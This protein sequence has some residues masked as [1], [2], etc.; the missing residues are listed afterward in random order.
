MPTQSGMQPLDLISIILPCFDEEAVLPATLERLDA[1]SIA[2]KDCDFEFIFIDDGSTDGTNNLLHAAARRDDRL[3]L[4]TLSRNFGQ[5]IAT[6]A[7]IDLANGGAV[8]LMDCDLQDPPELVTQMIARW[9]EGYDVVYG[10]RASREGESWFKRSTARGFNQVI[11]RLSEVPIPADS[12]D[13]RLMSRKVVDVLKQMPE[14][15]RFLRGMVAW[16]GFRQTSLPYD[17]PGRLAGTTKY[18]LRKMLRLALDGLLSFST[19]PLQASI[20]LGL[21]TAGLAVLG[22]FY[23]L[24]MRLFTSAWVEGWT[25]LMIAILFI[26]GVQLVSLGIIGEYIGRIYAEVQRRPLYIVR[27]MV[28]FERHAE[29]DAGVH[30]TQ[31]DSTRIP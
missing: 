11:N 26:G 29:A 31:R 9:R 24:F 14:R 12:G 13:F 17:R 2:Q 6:T 15:H 10:T 1:L 7:G 19:K 21:L 25:A 16:S 20:F 5:Q 22:I 18:P 28:G 3:R 23:A 30:E 27:D 8:V 4:I